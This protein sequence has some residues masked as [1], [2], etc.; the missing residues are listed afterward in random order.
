[1]SL[2][3][4][5][6]KKF[7][8]PADKP[9]NQA[10]A[11]SAITAG[12]VVRITGTTSGGAYFT[13]APAIADGVQS[14]L[15][16]V[17]ATSANSGDRVWFQE[18][19]TVPFD[20]SAGA[21]GDDV[22]LSDTVAGTLTLSS[23]IE[24]VGW[25]S[26]AAVAGRVLV[27]PAAQSSGGGGV[28]PTLWDPDIFTSTNAKSDAYTGTSLDAKW[29]E[30]D[31][32]SVQTVSVQ[33]GYVRLSTS[34]SSGTYETAGIIQAAPSDNY[35][36]VTARVRAFGDMVDNY[37][38]WG[39]IVAENL[40]ASGGNPST[41]QLHFLG[42]AEFNGPVMGAWRWQNYGTY[43]QA[44][45]QVGHSVEDLLVRVFVDRIGAKYTML[46]SKR[47][48]PYTWRAVHEH[49][50]GVP[51]LL[52][53]DSIG[54]AVNSNQGGVVGVTC[55]SFVVETHSDASTASMQIGHGAVP[56]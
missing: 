22:Y 41:A 29:E 32:G 31:P 14:G 42:G 5:K 28:S 17:A 10:Y 36:S 21:A 3:P 7:L 19:T 38:F 51:N 47:G 15:L 20:T 55:S 18:A 27:V 39:L 33:D 9:W 50:I 13:V 40:A 24:P 25:V 43:G 52:S 53:L 45:L 56:S 4:R 30:W 8:G 44:F 26:E 1:M 34:S 23:T 49:A 35:F 12:Q 54:L 37:S 16:A 6:R 11:D 48:E 46:I 2:D